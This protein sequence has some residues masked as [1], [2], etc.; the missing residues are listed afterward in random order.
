MLL[1]G[2]FMKNLDPR[3]WLTSAQGT[4]IEFLFG[5]MSQTVE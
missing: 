5:R 2:R 3:D 4:G 1:F